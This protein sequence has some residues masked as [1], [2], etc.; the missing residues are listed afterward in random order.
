MELSHT[1][2]EIIA[3]WQPFGFSTHI[4]TKKVS[5]LL[6]TPTSHTGTLD[7]MA[8]GVIVVLTGENRHKKYEYASWLKTYEFNL[9][10]G[11]STDSYDGLGLMTSNFI[12]PNLTE[13]HINLALVQIKSQKPY[14]QTIPPYSA[15]KV[16]GK[17]L[18]WYARSNMLAEVTLPTRSGEIYELSL[19]S[20]KEVNL[21]SALK[22]IIN[23]TNLVTGNLRQPVVLAQW[24]KFLKDVGNLSTYELVLRVKLTKGLYVRSLSQDICKQLDCTGFVS[25]ISRIDNGLYNKSN[26][27]TLEQLFG[28]N[29]NRDQKFDSIT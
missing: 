13:N 3:I 2:P 24:E 12:K 14:I 11:V 15:I 17:P 8:E 6:Q 27:V 10:L 23:R 5:E 28:S 29:Y 19:V 22:L 1:K 7:P 4:I 21:E 16:N 20:L 25:S 9:V 26:C 18:H